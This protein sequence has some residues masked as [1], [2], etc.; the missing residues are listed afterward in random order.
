M[1]KLSFFCLPF[2]LLVWLNSPAFSKKSQPP[3]LSDSTPIEH[4]LDGFPTEWPSDRFQKDENSGLQ[5]AFD[6]DANNLYIVVSVN[7]MAEQMKMMSMSMKMFI[8]L[9]A[10][11]KENMGIEFPVK[12]DL[13]QQS[14][15]GGGN[16][17]GGERTEGQEGERKAF[18]IQAMRQRLAMNLISMKIFGF[19]GMDKPKEVGLTMFNSAHLVYNWDTAN[20]FHIEYQIPMTMISEPASLDNKNITIGWKI[21]G[22]EIPS[23]AGAGGGGGFTGGRGGSGGG[24]RGPGGGGRPASGSGGSQDQ[25]ANFEKMREE[26]NIWAKYTFHIAVAPRGF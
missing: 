5:Y 2:F 11:K 21:L 23:G 19:E 6:N 15:G 9:K 25:Q 16:R 4:K 18:D 10:K 17:N 26:Q 12:R 13:I 20:A 14:F 1:F 3:V 24:G 7:D 22:I 8:D